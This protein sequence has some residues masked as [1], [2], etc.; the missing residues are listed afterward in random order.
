MITNLV[1][2][3]CGTWILCSSTELQK[4]K[5]LFYAH[6]SLIGLRA[7]QLPVGRYLLCTLWIVFSLLEKWISPHFS[8]ATHVLE[9]VFNKCDKVPVFQWR[10]CLPQILSQ[11]LSRLAGFG[12]P[13]KGRDWISL[14][15]VHEDGLP[16]IRT[17]MVKVPHKCPSKCCHFLK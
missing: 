1:C 13:G 16:S 15:I 8:A 2:T 12:S 3:A 9:Y 10:C 4:Y 5:I 11:Q 7:C 6:T 17:V 14:P